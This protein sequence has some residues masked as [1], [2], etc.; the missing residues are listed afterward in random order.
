MADKDSMINEDKRLIELIGKVFKEEFAQQEKNIS[1]LVSWNFS[2]TK[3]QTE[4]VKKEQLDLRKSIEFTENQ[5]EEKVSNAKN[6]LVDI[7]QRIEEIYYY[8]IDLDH[9]KQKLIDLDDRS[10]RN[11]LRVDRILET[12][13]DTWEDCEEK[14]QQ[15]F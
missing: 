15:V 12:L 5:L 11:N 3:Q 6:K 10:R 13:E 2:I 8:Q 9:V 7:E 4:E 1:N 14:L